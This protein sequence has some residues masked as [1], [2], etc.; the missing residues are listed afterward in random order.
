MNARLQTFK[1]LLTLVITSVAMA[2]IADV[3][4]NEPPNASP[5]KMTPELLKQ[6]SRALPSTS[7]LSYQLRTVEKT[8]RLTYAPPTDSLGLP[9]GCAQKS[10]AL[11]YDYRA[12]HAVYKPMR[13]LLPTI[14]GMTPDNLSIRR[15]K[16]VARYSF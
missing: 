5:A 15:N 3:P 10:G 13:K 14:P 7:G 9:H 8:R 2:G 11:C 4:R 1:W 16:V 6:A 12:G